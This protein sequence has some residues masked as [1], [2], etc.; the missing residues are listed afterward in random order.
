MRSKRYRKLLAIPLAA[1]LQLSALAA[2][3]GEVIVSEGF[4]LK[5]EEAV[6]DAALVIE[7]DLPQALEFEPVPAVGLTELSLRVLPDAILMAQEGGDPAPTQEKKGVGRWLK[8]HWYVPVL[9]AIVLGV[10]LTDD[11]DHGEDDDD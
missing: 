8:K 6:V 1:I 4:S 9:A 5:L 2:T 3:A 11:D 7:S 10:V